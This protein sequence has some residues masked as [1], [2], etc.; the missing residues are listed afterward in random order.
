MNYVYLDQQGNTPLIRAC[1]DNDIEEARNIL[2]SP[3]HH[4]NPRRNSQR[5]NPGHVNNEGMTAL[6]YA[7]EHHNSE[8]AILILKTNVSNPEH[9]TPQGETALSI[10]QEFPEMQ[11]FILEI[12]NGGYIDVPEINNYEFLEGIISVRKTDPTSIT[13]VHCI[14]SEFEIY[15]HHLIHSL[16]SQTEFVNCELIDTQFERGEFYEVEF[17]SCTI[18]DCYFNE[19]QIMNCVFGGTIISCDFSICEITESLFSGVQFMNDMEFNH[20]SFVNC[21]FVNV[22]FQ[23]VDPNLFQT[24]IFTNCRIISLPQNFERLTLTQQQRIGLGLEQVNIIQQ[25]QQQPI[26]V[27]YEV[28]NEFENFKNRLHGLYEIIKTEK[29][30]VVPLKIIEAFFIKFIRSNFSEEERTTAIEQL[31]EVLNKYR[32]SEYSQHPDI[33]KYVSAVYRFVKEQPKEFIDFYIRAF[34]Q[35]CY[36]AYPDAEAGQGVSCVQ[37]IIE[38]FVLILRQTALALCPENK[39]DNETYKQINNFFNNKIDKEFFNEYAQWFEN[40][41]FI[42]NQHPTMTPE[43]WKNQF[44]KGLKQHIVEKGFELNEEIISDINKYADDVNYAFET[45]AFGGSSSKR[46]PIKKPLRKTQKKHNS[47]HKTSKNSKIKKQRRTNKK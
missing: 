16:F 22:S 46:K 18:R 37:G 5:I 33:R 7:C 40:H 3:Y 35:D 10:A 32:E 14:F 34:I 2:E 19:Q 36:F 45:G 11:D 24:T 25:Q 8:L 30:S 17:E 4:Q 12:I 42:N 31:K 26:G 20:T 28:H 21:T 47:Y 9:I 43:Q 41:F 39:C 6:I 29:K 1:I 38:K 13:L 15:F 27:A 23:D 44:I